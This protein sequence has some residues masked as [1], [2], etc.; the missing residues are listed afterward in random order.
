[1]KKSNLDI[2][3]FETDSSLKRKNLTE[4]NKTTNI[5][6]LLNRVRFDEK[7][8]FKKKI[9][10]LSLLITTVTFISFFAII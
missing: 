9:I 4:R 8:D 6:I 7:Q 5:N 10:F 3:T 2:N 1:M